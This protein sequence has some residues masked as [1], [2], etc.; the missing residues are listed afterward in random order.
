MQPPGRCA[1]GH[2]G[3]LRARSSAGAGLVENHQQGQCHR[4]RCRLRVVGVW[5]P[6]AGGGMPHRTGLM[7]RKAPVPTPLHPYGGAQQGEIREVGGGLPH[8]NG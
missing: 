6:G 3:L 4:R 8:G 7:C 1:A 5:S 2:R